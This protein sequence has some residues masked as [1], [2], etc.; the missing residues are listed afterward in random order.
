VLDGRCL[1]GSLSRQGRATFRGLTAGG[2]RCPY[3]CGLWSGVKTRGLV[4]RA[5]DGS[6]AMRWAARPTT[7]AFGARNGAVASGDRQEPR[8]LSQNLIASRGGRAPREGWGCIERPL[9]WT[10]RPCAVMGDGVSIARGLHGLYYVLLTTFDELCCGCSSPIRARTF[11]QRRIGSQ[12]GPAASA[13]LVSSARRWRT[14]S[15]ATSSEASD[16]AAAAS[17]SCAR[18]AATRS[19]W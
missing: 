8:F 19:R 4:A 5:G 2:R 17:G 14:S 1:D 13:R 12:K 16:A 15:A 11:H 18:A 7:A 3:R 9:G 10:V 6:R